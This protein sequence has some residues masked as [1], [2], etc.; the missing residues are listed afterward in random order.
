[1]FEVPYTLQEH[2]Q[3]R[4]VKQANRGVHDYN[5]DESS[6]RDETL[7]PHRTSGSTV[8][9]QQTGATH[10][11]IHQ[12]T[13]DKPRKRQNVALNINNDSTHSV[14]ML[15]F[16]AVSSLLVGETNRY[17]RQYLDTLDE[18]PS[19]V[20]D[21]TESEML[22]FLALIIQ[23]GHDVRDSF[24]DYWTV[25]EQLLTPFYSKTMTHDRFLHILRHLHFANN[26]NAIDSN[27]PK[28]DRLWKI[29]RIFDILNDA[30]STYYTP[31]EYLAVDEVIVLFKGRVNF[32]QYIPKKHKRFGIKIYKLC[33]MSGYMCDTDMY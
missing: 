20:P 32:K 17:Y 4:T 29:R 2:R 31:T 13:G 24:K 14:F 11:R 1:V 28:Y 12:F 15:Y 27:D 22:L 3:G 18:R 9:R 25:S 33:N 7:L 6:D 21:I 19:P 5:T 30:F 26:K 10:T 16:A 23:M 8:W